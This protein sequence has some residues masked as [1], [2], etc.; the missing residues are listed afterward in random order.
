[1][2]YKPQKSNSVWWTW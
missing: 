1:M 2:Q